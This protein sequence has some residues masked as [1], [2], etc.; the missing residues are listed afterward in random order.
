M[1]TRRT[2]HVDGLA[3]AAPIPV[4]ARKGPLLASSGISGAD[5][6]TT[7]MPDDLAGQVDNVF[8]NIR[9]ILEASGG[10]A[11]DV[12]KLTFFVRE[13]SA[14]D[15]INIRWLEMYPDPDQRPAR[16]TLIA[17]LP[18]GVLVQCEL[19]AYCD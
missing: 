4:A 2:I 10:R 18:P 6:V 17:D 8:A 5:P 11:D 3:H 16:H 13:R 19:L 14:R 12:V 1:S 15:A 9:R 7:R